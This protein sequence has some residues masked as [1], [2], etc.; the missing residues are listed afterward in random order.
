MN[1]KIKIIIIGGGFGGTYTARYLSSLSQSGIADITLISRDNYFL[2]TPL[3]HEVATGSLTPNNV[4]E[5][6]EEILQGKKIKFIQDEVVSIDIN[7]KKVKT[8][9]SELEYDYLVISSGAET[10]YYGTIGAKENSFTLKNLNDAIT[11][12]KSIID[13]HKKEGDISSIVIGAG[14]TGVELAAELIEF[15]HTKVTLVAA[16][17]DVLHQFPMKLQQIAHRELLRKNVNVMVD[18]V[19][20]SVEPGKVIFKDGTSISAKNII[21]VAGVKP[22]APIIDGIEYEK[23]GRIKVDEYLRINNRVFALG[24]VSGT[25][26]MLAQ[27]AT[28]QGMSVAG[29]IIANITNKPLLPFIFNQKGLLVSLGKWYAAGEISGITMKGP[30]M[31]LIWRTIYLFN[32]HCWRKRIEIVV[33]WIINLFSPR[34][35]TEI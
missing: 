32:F 3:L 15:L 5:S 18:R 33:E 35:I 2:F 29:N 24:D 34:D 8:K 17:K 7:N 10:N 13:L 23:S 4:I 9:T 25:T 22:S 14:P 30:I 6:I 28:Q 26:P 19:V 31:W 1:N 16:S 21:W 11:I 20:T 27:V 12:R